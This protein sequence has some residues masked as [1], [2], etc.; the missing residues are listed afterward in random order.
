MMKKNY[1]KPELFYENFTLLDAI[2]DC[3]VKGGPTT[4]ETCSYYDEDVGLSLFVAGVSPDCEWTPE[5]YMA[6]S[7][8]GLIFGS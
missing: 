2:T 1:I 4:P 8:S 5:N 3:T 6:G 7:I